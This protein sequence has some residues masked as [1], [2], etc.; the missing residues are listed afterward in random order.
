MGCAMSP[1]L[2]AMAIV[3]IVRYTKECGRAAEIVKNQ[4][5]PPTCAFMADLTLL[6]QSTEESQNILEKLKELM[7]WARM[8]LS[9]KNQEVW[10]CE[11]ENCMSSTI[12][13]S[14][15]NLFQ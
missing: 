8:K 9:P 2:F 10:C 1:I 5:L 11:Q 12:V 7:N 6:N 14:V 15:G 3:I 13:P 4:I